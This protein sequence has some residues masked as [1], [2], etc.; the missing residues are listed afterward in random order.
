MIAFDKTFPVTDPSYTDSTF[1]Y[2]GD[3]KYPLVATNS[4]FIDVVVFTVIPAPIYTGFRTAPLFN[5]EDILENNKISRVA[6]SQQDGDDLKEKDIKLNVKTYRIIVDEGTATI[7][8]GSTIKTFK[9]K[10][11]SPILSQLD[12][13]VA[14]TATVHSMSCYFN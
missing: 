6:W 8:N 10:N 2:D 3:S 12:P 5:A 14:D 13:V 11:L 7:P 9:V 4:D 1:Y